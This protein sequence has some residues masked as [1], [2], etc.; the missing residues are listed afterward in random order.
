[1]PEFRTVA[2]GVD[3]VIDRGSSEIFF[4][5]VT[6]SDKPP[7][8]CLRHTTVPHVRDIYARQ[9]T[10]EHHLGVEVHIRLEEPVQEGGISINLAQPGMTGDYTVIPLPL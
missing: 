10:H 5:V 4:F 2:V 7:I 1:M 9:A 3:E 6:G 8:V